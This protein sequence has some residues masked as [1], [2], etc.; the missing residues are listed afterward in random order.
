MSENQ[1][2]CCYICDKT[3]SFKSKSEH[4]NCKSYK[5]KEKYGT[6][7]KEH[8]YIK[9]ETDE[10]IYILNDASKD[11]RNEF[12]ILL[13]IDMYMIINLKKWKK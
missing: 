11:C 10:M 3:I 6:V 7:V 12:F 5:Q 2:W 4:I 1:I 8:N 9:S 13:N